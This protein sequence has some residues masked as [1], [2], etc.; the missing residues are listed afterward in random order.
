MGMYKSF[1]DSEENTNTLMDGLKEYM[2]NYPFDEPTM[3]SIERP[4]HYQGGIE[5]IEY[6]NKNGLGYNEGNVVKYVTRHKKKNKADDIRK[7]IQYC[8]FILRYE[9][10]EDS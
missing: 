9:Y 10:G 2:E 3:D 7:A 4:S 8:K 5:A 1:L 6:I